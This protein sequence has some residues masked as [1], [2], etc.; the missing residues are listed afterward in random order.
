[1]P[2]LKQNSMR[3]LDLSRRRAFVAAAGMLNWVFPGILR[4]THCRFFFSLINLHLPYTVNPHW[5][6][7]C[8]TI[9]SLAWK[10]RVLIGELK[11]PVTCYVA[12]TLFEGFKEWCYTK[13]CCSIWHLLHLS[14]AEIPAISWKSVIYIAE[15]KYPDGWCPMFKSYFILVS[16][17]DFCH[18][19]CGYS[20][21]GK[22]DEGA[23][24]VS[25]VEGEWIRYYVQQQRELTLKRIGKIGM[26]GR[27]GGEVRGYGNK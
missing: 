21:L 9:M 5:V 3:G 16:I 27:G 17:S 4:F 6:W 20:H 14:S 22:V 13:S 8:T 23:W 26:E 12:S 1:M 11:S 15:C 18:N 19:C 7:T 24:E 2:H 25:R 10:W